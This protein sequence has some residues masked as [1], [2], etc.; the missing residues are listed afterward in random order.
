M[1]LG[2][3]VGLVT[4]LVLLT[5]VG[6]TQPNMINEEPVAL[7]TPEVPV[8]EMKLL[9]TPTPTLPPMPTPVARA[10]NSEIQINEYQLNEEDVETIARL[11]WSSP[12]RTRTSKAALAWVVC[13]RVDS[14][15]FPSTI[16]EVVVKSEFSFYDRKAH[17][18]EE[19][20]EIAR[21]V[22]NQWLSERD[23]YESGRLVPANGLFTQF[24][25]ENNRNLN[26]LD[27]R[28]GNC[29]YYPMAGAYEY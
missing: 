18:S 6:F 19:N 12:L 4:M 2:F 24:A 25:G 3:V 17:I 27:K 9:Y 7:V 26:I 29:V 16:R 14:D 21:L 11:L 13:N 5:C 8:I 23:G 1:K 20:L 28:G 15:I 10:T 22:L